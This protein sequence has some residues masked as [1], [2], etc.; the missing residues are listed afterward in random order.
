VAICFTMHVL[1]P[2]QPAGVSK[3]SSLL[4]IDCAPL[5]P[6]SWCQHMGVLSHANCL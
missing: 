4:M 2:A 3:V 5:W 6:L 1:C